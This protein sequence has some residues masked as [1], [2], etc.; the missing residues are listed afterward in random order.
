MSHVYQPIML[1]KLLLSNGQASAAEIAAEIAKHDPTQLE[2]YAQIVKRMVGK[3]LTDSRKITTKSGEEYQLI[4]IEDLSQTEIKSLVH[5]CEQR[6]TAFLAKRGEKIFD[7]R[8]TGHRPISGSVRYAVLKRA[9]FRCEL[10][11]VH[12]EDRWLE[13]DHINPKSLGGKDELEN[14]QALCYQCNQSKGNTDD[15]DFREQAKSYECREPG[16]IFCEIPKE[17]IVHETSLSYVIRDNY[18]VTPLHTLII[19][20]RHVADFFGLYQP[21]INAIN[22]QIQFQRDVLKNQDSEIVGFNIGANCGTAAGQTVFHCHIHL[23]PRRLND[24]ENPTGGVRNVIPGKGQ[25]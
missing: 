8:R 9:K 2:Y 7:H 11:G 25:W 24:V 4:G 12:D 22:R 5:E 13:V 16:C 21:E 18:P 17:R 10:C 20:K 23:V 15:E 6:L 14:Y 19:P 1:M 3:V